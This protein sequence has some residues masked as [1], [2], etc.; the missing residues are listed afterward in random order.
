M[1]KRKGFLEKEEIT[2]VSA[3][4]FAEKSYAGTSMRDIAKG[5][6]VSIASVYYYFKNKEDI[7]FNIIE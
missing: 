5:L 3:R 7:L 4:L 2:E 1:R 6:N